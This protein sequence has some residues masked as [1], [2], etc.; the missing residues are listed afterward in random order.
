MDFLPNWNISQGFL[1]ISLISSQC[2]IVG[3]IVA[4]ELYCTTLSRIFSNTG[5]SLNNINFAER[6]SEAAMGGIYLGCSVAQ[7]GSSVA[8]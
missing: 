1:Y 3:C 5:I 4:Q 2:S 8:Q 7:L 6:N